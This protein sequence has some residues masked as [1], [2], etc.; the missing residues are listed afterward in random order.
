[1]KVSAAWRKQTFEEGINLSRVRHWENVD[2]AFSKTASLTLTPFASA[3]LVT[4]NRI[5][6]FIDQ[7]YDRLWRV[8]RR[9]G[10]PEA[11]VEDAAQEVLLVIARRLGDVSPESEWAFA[12]ST[13]R[14][15]AA[16]RRRMAKARPSTEGDDLLASIADPRQ[17]EAAARADDCRVLDALLG[18][19]PDEQREV[20]VLVEL[21]GMT[22]GE[23]ARLLGVPSGTIA[24]RL[25]RARA[26][27]EEAVG[28]IRSKRE[29]MEQPS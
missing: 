9:F 1:V 22:M 2:Q 7:H 11:T 10:V 29:G 16:D 20:I 15:V 28:V 19:L 21:E 8:L 17:G 23:V 25:R 4:V 6:A 12:Y 14:R 24:S 3:P 27:L 26:N 5:R 18:D 13:A